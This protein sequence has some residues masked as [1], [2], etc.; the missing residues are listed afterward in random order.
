MKKNAYYMERDLQESNSNVRRSMCQYNNSVA[1]IDMSHVKSYYTCTNVYMSLS[2][3][4]DFD[5]L[6]LKSV[7]LKLFNTKVII[8]K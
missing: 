2:W 3:C 6:V 4:Y 7:C 1:I 5:R 8:L